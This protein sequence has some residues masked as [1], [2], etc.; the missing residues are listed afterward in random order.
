MTILTR[1]IDRR[2]ALSVAELPAVA[3]LLAAC[4]G[5]PSGSGG[6]PG[7]GAN[8]VQPVIPSSDLAVGRN[9]LSLA[10]LQLKQGATSPSPITDAKL[11]FKFFFPIQPQAVAKGEATPEF[12]FVD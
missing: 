8:R 6:R 3:P 9:R 7:E 12:R 11:N 2:T 5:A 1:R 10:L 4:G